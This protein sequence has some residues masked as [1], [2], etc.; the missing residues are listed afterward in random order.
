[1]HSL[2]KCTGI[3]L[4]LC[5]ILGF[6]P[7]YRK[8]PKESLLFVCVLFF[9]LFWRIFSVNISFRYYC[10]FIYLF[11][12]FCSYIKD[13]PLCN[14]LY[15]F[16]VILFCIVSYQSCSLFSSFNNSYILDLQDVCYK[17]SLLNPKSPKIIPQKEHLRILDN[18]S[19]ESKDRFRYFDFKTNNI[20][21]S[22]IVFENISFNSD[23]YFFVPE[24]IN[25][26]LFLCYDPL[27][28][29]LRKICNF[30]TNHNHSKLISIYKSS[31]YEPLN[32]NIFPQFLISP[33]F[34]QYSD[35]ILSSK[36]TIHHLSDSSF[37]IKGVYSSV[38][39]NKYILVLNNDFITSVSIQNTGDVATR[40]YIG[41]AVYSNDRIM[42]DGKNFPYNNINKILHVVSSQ[43]DTVTVD[44][45][46]E[47][48]SN[49]F[50]AL[51]ADEDL[52]D[53]PNT[54]LL[55]GRIVEIK[56][57]PNDQAE[58]KLSKPIK[59]PIPNGTKVRINGKSGAYLYN[60]IRVLQP[61]E[62]VFLSSTIKK[63]DTWLQY[64]SPSRAF[65]RGVFYVKP[66]ILSYSIDPNMEN[67]ITVDQYSIS[68]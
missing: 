37:S 35:T 3:I 30:T 13:Y 57:L 28:N 36:N 44:S 39:S 67:I 61:G 66:L 64:I 68:Y 1:M 19:S 14:S 15:S 7:Y 60:N 50:L 55:E 43:N 58:I 62:K 48:D 6:Y 53:L 17:F 25:K 46:P 22:E 65:P 16:C 32:N 21:F 11:L 49:C 34:I 10:I 23:T 9:C 4:F 2:F 24:S 54:S 45:F 26:K 41:F 29:Y 52:S 20:D 8:N 51:N 27:H 38:F 56:R 31:P 5:A 18:I 42:L 40:I 12:L 47:W 59:E 63:D 33:G